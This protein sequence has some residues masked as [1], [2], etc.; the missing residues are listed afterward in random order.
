MISF[1]VRSNIAQRVR[2]LSNLEKQ[3]VPIATAKALTFSAE[4]VIEV[5]R[6][7]MTRVFKNPVTWTLNSLYLKPATIRNPVA[8]VYFK[9]FAPKG[10]P[11]GRYLYPEIHGGTR[12]TKSGERKLYPFMAGYRFAMPGAAAD[13][14]AHGNIPG[15]TMTRILSQVKA[16]GGGAN[17]TAASKK[18]NR[19][20]VKQRYFIPKTAASGLRPGV[21]ID[22]SRVVNGK[23]ISVA[24]PVLIFT[25]KANYRPRYPFYELS[26][27][28]AK[29]Q[30]PQ[31]FD[32]QLL[33]E[34]RRA[35]ASLPKAA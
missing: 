29:A 31:H 21:Y 35:F 14:D 33:R 5:Q 24:R 34:M 16:L 25:S 9:D 6:W 4:T 26:L 32:R 12:D 7:K 15:G 8:T 1:D 11:A 30:F 2:E 10:V 13:L 18:R 19:G 22:D 3:L 17:Q 27:A 28:T 20:R 23:K